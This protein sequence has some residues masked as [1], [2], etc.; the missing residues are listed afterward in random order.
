M[1]TSYRYGGHKTL[2]K[3]GKAVE[4][5]MPPGDILEIKGPF[6]PVTIT[7]PRA[8]RETFRKM[9]RETPSVQVNALID[10]GASTSIISTVVADKLN[11]V[12]TGYQRIFSVQ[13]EQEQ[14]VYYGYILFPWGNGREIP[15]ASC[16]IKDIDC[17]LGRDI[18]RNWYLTY[19]GT[20]GSITICD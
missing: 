15:I 9:G 6:L 8:A 3:D 19:N 2:Y 10:T 11:L 5:D 20:D 1:I 17:L 4:V 13:D 12:H 16:P 18:L 14:P 7:H